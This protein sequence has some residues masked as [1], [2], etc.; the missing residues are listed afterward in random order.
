LFAQLSSGLVAKYYFNS[1]NTVDDIG[2]HNATNTGAVLTSDR[3]GNANSAFLLDGS[4]NIKV[5]Y[6][7]DLNVTTG[8]SISVWI[9]QSNTSGEQAIVS[10][11]LNLKSADQYILMTNNAKPLIAIGNPTFS[12]NGVLCTPTVSAAAWHHLVFEWTNTG[13]HKLF[14]DGVETDSVRLTS[15]ATI[16]SSSLNDLYF[17]AQVVSGS[18]FTRKFTG[19]IDDIRIY[20]RGLS[21]S[22]VAELYDEANPLSTDIVDNELSKQTIVYPNPANTT[23]NIDLGNAKNA[24]VKILSSNGKVLMT[25]NN[26]EGITQFDISSL[27][28][29]LYFTEV[30]NDGRVIRNKFIV[31]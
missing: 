28:V 22:E 21:H 16:N 24:S 5:P 6:Y 14:Y 9:N 15:F 11:W 29:G 1:G 27:P 19:S 7:S 12:A 2:S 18:T 17:G 8:L 26:L 3:F 31:Q 23:I 4:D 10:R 25:Q 20:N 13:D 30:I